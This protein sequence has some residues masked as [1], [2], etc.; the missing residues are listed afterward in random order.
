MVRIGDGRA[1][2]GLEMPRIGGTGPDP[3]S[4]ADFAAVDLKPATDTT[5]LARK[6]KDP[7]EVSRTAVGLKRNREEWL[8]SPAEMLTISK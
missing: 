2:S 8:R 6:V 1:S 4:R 7:P 3:T 5:I